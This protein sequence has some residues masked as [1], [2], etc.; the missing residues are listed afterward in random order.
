MASPT[1]APADFY[2]L[3]SQSRFLVGGRF[4]SA[5]FIV[6]L[7]GSPPRELGGFSGGTAS[8]ACDVSPGGHQ[9]AAAAQNGEDLTL[10]V[11][12]V[13]T[14]DER[15]FDLP[16]GSPSADGGI[17]GGVSTVS[18]ADESTLYTA[19]D[20]GVW[21]WDLGTGTHE[22]IYA[23]K[24]SIGFAELR[25]D[26]RRAL[27][28]IMSL[29][30]ESEGEVGRLELLNME[31]GIA[32]E[33]RAFSPGGSVSFFSF[34][35][36]GDVIAVSDEAGI[37]RVGNLSDEE[38]HLLLGHEGPVQMVEIS[39]DGKWIASTGED[40][41]LRLWP[42]PDLDKPPLHTLPHDELIAKL[43]SLTNIRVVRDSDS[44]E[45]WSVALDPF[46]GWAEVPTWR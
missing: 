22:L 38:P 43:K 28:Q 40:D 13:A 30:F 18:F 7:D 1:G 17:Q 27:V 4:G 8:Q 10:R 14:G 25:P 23:L 16:P 12:D 44:E 24:G 35:P 41:T 33:L 32:H 31:T 20:G 6:P 3:D 42:M 2:C 46:P 39:P 19:G 15:V 36:S 9:M 34:G 26:A 21:R 29:D 5:F 37:I 11:W 45:G